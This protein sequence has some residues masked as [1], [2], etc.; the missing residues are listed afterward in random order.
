MPR[1]TI[2]IDTE[3]CKG[4]GLCIEA[5]PQDVLDSSG[6]LNSNGYEYVEAS[7]PENCTG[8]S[9]C[10]KSCPDVAITVYRKQK[11]ATEG[12]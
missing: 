11:Q 1:G 2:R 8:C 10:A 4:C 5:C 3:R 7:H 9:N 6:D 12:V